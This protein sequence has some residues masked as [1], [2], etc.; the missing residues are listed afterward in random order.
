MPMIV[1]P[2][3]YARWLDPANADVAD[4]IAPY[5]AVEM[6]FYPV[7]TRVNNVRHDEASL[8]EHTAPI[9]DGEA[10]HEPPPHPPEQESLF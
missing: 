1:A 5:P 8:I 7:S 6:T 10:E 2:R 3:D 4:L 9:A